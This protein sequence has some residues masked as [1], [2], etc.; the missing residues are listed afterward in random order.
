[1]SLRDF[2]ARITGRPAPPR[3]ASQRTRSRS[4]QTVR[5]P[6][7]ARP[8]TVKAPDHALPHV[9]RESVTSAKPSPPVREPVEAPPAGPSQHPPLQADASAAKK[10]AVDRPARREPEPGGLAR[11]EVVGVLV[12]I[13]GELKGDV[14][15]IYDGENRLGRSEAGEVVLPS[16]WISREHAMLVHHGGVFAIVSVNERNRTYVNGQEV[17]GVEVEDADAIRLGRTTFRFKTIEGM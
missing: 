13:D 16:K 2:L 11:D 10:D 1:L 7:A 12:A 4:E 5:L 15:R 6:V 14:F 17:D 3:G 8:G 9:D